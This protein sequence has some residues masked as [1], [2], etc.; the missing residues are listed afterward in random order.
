MAPNSNVR[1]N[2]VHLKLWRW[3]KILIW[4]ILTFTW[5][6]S[7]LS[8]LLICIIHQQ[9]R[10]RSGGSRGRVSGQARWGQGPTKQLTWKWEALIKQS[11][12]PYT[13][14]RGPP[15]NVDLMF[16][17]RRLIPRS[18]WF[19]LKSNLNSKPMSRDPSRNL[20]AFS[21]I[22]W[23]TKLWNVHQSMVQVISNQSLHNSSA[24]DEKYSS[25]WF[26]W[27]HV[28][29]IGRVWSRDLLSWR[30]T[31]QRL[32]NSSIRI[33]DEVVNRQRSPPSQM[34]I[35]FPPGRV[36]SLGSSFA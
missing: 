22:G 7:S 23:L 4:K 12:S 16:T 14:T 15:S 13:H 28:F 21:P 19:R 2:F 34:L 32:I 31:S 18:C 30:C 25:Y 36:G 35:Q 27:P 33:V 24:P 17:R 1:N 8:G 6:S 11:G 5:T 20:I 3:L 26:S 9:G 10:C 29:L